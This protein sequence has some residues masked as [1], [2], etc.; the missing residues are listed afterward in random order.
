MESSELDNTPLFSKPRPSR[1]V[2][3]IEIQTTSL[4]SS[5]S[6]TVL[7]LLSNRG[8][9]QSYLWGSIRTDTQ[10]AARFSLLKFR[11]KRF[12]TSPY[13]MKQL[14][15]KARTSNTL[16]L[17]VSSDFF[18]RFTHELLFSRASKFLSTATTTRLSDFTSIRTFYSIHDHPGFP[19]CRY[20][21]EC[22]GK[23][24]FSAIFGPFELLW[25]M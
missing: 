9:R 10:K 4:S 22:Q 19:C 21:S 8:Y 3:D 24:Q 16:N 12:Q 25:V 6:R 20:H 1:T 13:A 15:R 11:I 7:W 5:S 23:V 14:L 2:L 17:T 18:L